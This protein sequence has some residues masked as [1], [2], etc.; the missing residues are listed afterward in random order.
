MINLNTAIR[1]LVA[2][3]I[4]LAT[5]GA[6][7]PTTS[8]GRGGQVGSGDSKAGCFDA[9]GNRL[10]R[11]TFPDG[12]EGVVNGINFANMGCFTSF[13]PIVVPAAKPSAEWNAPVQAP[14]VFRPTTPSSPTAV[15]VSPSTIDENFRGFVQVTIDGLAT[16]DTIR[17]EKFQ[18]NNT[19]GVIDISAILEQSLLLTDGVSNVIGGVANVNVPADT[20]PADG[21]IAARIPFL[22]SSVPTTVGQYVFRFSSPTGSFA[23]LTARFTVTNVPD[24]QDITGQV[25]ANGAPMPNAYVVLLETGGGS[26]D[27]VA[28]TIADGTGNYSFGAAPGQYDMVAVHRGFVGAFGK[29]VE[30]T[31]GVN[32]HKLRNLTMEAGTRTISGQVRDNKTNAGLPAVQ[33]VFKTDSGR[34]AVDYTDAN[35]NFSTSVTPDKWTVGLASSAVSQIGYVAPYAAVAVDTSTGNASNVTLAAAKATTLL[36]GTV[37]DSNGAPLAG[38]DLDATDETYRFQSDG[39]TDNSGN[40]V[41]AISSGVWAVDASASGLETLHDLA[42][43]P[44]KLYAAEGQA[45]NVNFAASKASAQ[46]S[47]ALKDN[48]GAGISDITYQALRDN[49]RFVRFG[50]QADGSFNVGLSAGTWSCRPLPDSAAHVDLIFVSP[51]PIT[52]TDAQNLTG[53]TFQALQ[54][55][56]HVNVTVKDQN[57][58]PRPR[59]ELALGYALN[60]Q[61]YVSFAYTDAHGMA[62]LPAYDHAWGL[63]GD[64]E[65]LAANGFREFAVQ[66]VT[67]SGSDVNVALT[68]EALPPT[69]NTLVNLSTRGTVQTGDNV[70]IGGFIIPGLEPKKVVVRAIGPSL[71]GSAISNPLANPTLTLFNGAGTQIAFNDD[72]IDSP[73][74]QAIIDT[75]LAPKN[76][77]ESAILQRLTPG[78]Y[79]VR[80]AGV[81]NTTGI[82]L[83]ELYDLQSFSSSTLANIST[84]GRVNTGE[85]V[86]IAGYIVGGYKAQRVVVRAIG[87]S[88]S[89]FGVAGALADPLLEL[90]NAQGTILISNNDWQDTQR[91][92]L[93]DTGLP[94]S[95][96][97][98]SALVTSLTPGNYTAIVS[99]VGG[100]T[101]VGLAEVY[102]VTR[103]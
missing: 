47:G 17:L 59:I 101:G 48:N 54:P 39:V 46:L 36:Y 74:K 99:G 66:T 82:A 98:E 67:V 37:T 23:P 78:N 76:D 11:T 31:L 26:Y 86:L 28:G 58:T 16:G 102:N 4:L 70:L 14:V 68:L 24:A 100:G 7:T 61:V 19:A 21:R 75:T 33:V 79:T 63:A 30:L 38:L 29:G 84:R 25:T 71:T 96:T 6:L 55:T 51:L 94:P 95:N 97:K 44:K 49:G 1:R 45:T 87:P 91:Q 89:Q 12:S 88:L 93:I 92:E 18:V 8:K 57:G 77:K 40:Y 73:D 15:G 20:T 3:A 52:L 50:T 60:N 13:V 90:R 9:D 69:G 35:G 34:F 5:C 2:G 43:L 42:P 72:W 41:I 62:S 10:I 22:D 64:P 85:N 27:F 80:V 83:V 65:N 32:E 56:R 103:N 81:N 53:V